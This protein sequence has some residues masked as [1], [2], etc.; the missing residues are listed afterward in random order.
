MEKA[1]GYVHSEVD[2]LTEE[3]ES[4]EYWQSFFCSHALWNLN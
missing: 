1:N 3:Q 4:M 2:F